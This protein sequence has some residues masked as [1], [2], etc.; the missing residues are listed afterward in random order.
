MSLQLRKC[1]LWY[2][3]ILD[4]QS[5][6]LNQDGGLSVEF[7]SHAVQFPIIQVHYKLQSQPKYR[8]SQ[9]GQKWGLACLC[10][11]LLSGL[12]S[13]SLQWSVWSLC[14]SVNSRVWCLC[15]PLRWFSVDIAD[16]PSAAWISSA[17]GAQIAFHLVPQVCKVHRTELNSSH[18]S[19]LDPG[20][21]LF[22]GAPRPHL[23]GLILAR[24]QA[25]SFLLMLH[26]KMSNR[27]RPLI[28]L[29]HTVF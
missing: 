16:H 20:A 6:R 25:Q 22:S 15:G 17:Q 3:H 11:F 4:S 29:L 5:P 10:E 27:P 2:H 12:Q 21:W 19:R 9:S 28:N 1:L 24:Q 14:R 8:A 13:W 23:E 26:K 7:R 18:N